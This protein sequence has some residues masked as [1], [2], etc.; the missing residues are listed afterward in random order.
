MD[1]HSILYSN[2]PL[3]LCVLVS[4]GGKVQIRVVKRHNE[5]IGGGVVELLAES[6]CMPWGLHKF[7]FY[8][9][10]GLMLKGLDHKRFTKADQSSH[11]TQRADIGRR[12]NICQVD[13]SPGDGMAYTFRCG[14]E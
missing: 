4:N 1:I 2:S 7:H 6:I 9:C 5:L 12:S 14:S 10:E 13:A 8:V 11:R 3:L